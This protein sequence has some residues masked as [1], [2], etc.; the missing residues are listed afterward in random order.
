[1]TSQQRTPASASPTSGED[2]QPGAAARILVIGEV[3]VDLIPVPSDTRKAGSNP[4][5]D[6]V[7]SLEGRF[8]GSP[9]NVAVGLVRLG[10]DTAL[11]ARIS[12]TG[13]GPWLR[14]HLESEGIDLTPS[15]EAAQPTTLAVVTLDDAGNATYEF[16]G[17]T[18]ADFHWEIAE[19]PQLET[20]DGAVVHTG[21][22][23][24]AMAPGGESLRSWVADLK[25]RG[26][27]LISYDPNPR[28]SIMKREEILASVERW[29]PLADLIKASD[30]DLDV[31]CPGEP[32]E[33]VAARW[34]AAGAADPSRCS[35]A[36][37]SGDGPQ[38]VVVTLGEHGARAFT[39]SGLDVT[40][41]ARPV[42]VV[43]TVGAGDSFTSGLLWALGTE[44]FLTL[45]RLPELGRAQLR[46][47]I[48][49][50]LTVA[51][52]T[53]GRPGADPP[54]KREISLEK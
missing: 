13:Y 19:L 11:G 53:V 2:H 45:V 44:G 17:P 49:R 29:V 5:P 39:R 30:E 16:H 18:S 8:G 28:P 40:L 33:D 10:M 3:L 6:T 36:M 50:A 38:L 47:V 27:C 26:R 42:E 52:V 23:A 35:Q 54:H 51:A 25:Q 4:P 37:T 15:V 21:S 43:D 32:V 31:L 9:A 20:M 46:T 34:L 22:L 48:E 7:L 24:T 1:M 14:R 12:G 41:P